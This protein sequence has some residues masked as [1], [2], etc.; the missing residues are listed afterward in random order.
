MTIKLTTEDVRIVGTF[1]RMIGVHVRDCL[2]GE[3]TV[4]F[5]V[6]PGK[7]GMA[8]GRNGIKIKNISLALRKKVKIFEYADTL[9]K[10]V[11]NLIPCA[12]SIN[13]N[14]DVVTVSIPQSERSTVIGKNGNNIK[15]IRHFLNRHFNI[16]NLR[17]K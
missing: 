4:Y 17:L 2:L 15:M 12:N 5:L 6:E 1:E 10:L 9:E 13:I 7:M 8:I 11:H 14:N 3:E 16:K